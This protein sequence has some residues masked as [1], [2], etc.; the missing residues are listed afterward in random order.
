MRFGFVPVLLIGVGKMTLAAPTQ[1]TFMT[2]ESEPVADPF[3][4][5]S[6]IWN[7][8]EPDSVAALTVAEIDVIAVYA[9][10]SADTIGI[11]FDCHITP[12]PDRLFL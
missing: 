11:S 7:G 9:R 2:S 4:E 5:F 8:R 6:C 10:V 12:P 3:K 1:A